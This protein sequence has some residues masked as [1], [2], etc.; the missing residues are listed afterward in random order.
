MKEVV[1]ISFSVTCSN[2]LKVNKDKCNIY[3]VIR[4]C[5]RK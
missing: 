4:D 5:G 1:V 2:I 3:W